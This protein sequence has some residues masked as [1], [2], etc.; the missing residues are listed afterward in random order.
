[1]CRGQE[2]IDRATAELQKNYSKATHAVAQLKRIRYKQMWR[3]L[4]SDW[5]GA[6]STILYFY[7]RGAE[8]PLTKPTKHFSSDLRTW[9]QMQ[10]KSRS[11]KENRMTEEVEVNNEVGTVLLKL[12]VIPVKMKVGDL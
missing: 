2:G 5:L 3:K 10:P 8:I 6:V 4:T 9:R 7:G 11:T 12:Y 1:M